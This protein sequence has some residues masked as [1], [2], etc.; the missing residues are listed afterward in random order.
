MDTTL[1]INMTYGKKKKEDNER[2]S[3]I[4]LEDDGEM[5]RI[6]IQNNFLLEKQFRKI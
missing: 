1:K 3:M 5:R 2:K 4:E 6:I